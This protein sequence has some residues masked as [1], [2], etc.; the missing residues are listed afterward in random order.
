M[1]GRAA[2]TPLPAVF[3]ERLGPPLGELA[4]A[5]SEFLRA[6]AAALARRRV[7][8]ECG[9]VQ[10]ALK[11]YEAGLAALRSEGLSSRRE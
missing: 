7:G 4:T 10:S 5:G 11:A 6:N 3:A 8:P 1:F 2:V 9:P